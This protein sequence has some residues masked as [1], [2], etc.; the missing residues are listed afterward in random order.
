MGER[1]NVKASRRP[2]TPTERDLLRYMLDQH[3]TYRSMAARFGV[4]T[5]TIKRILMREGIAEFEGAKYAVAPSKS[6]QIWERP[7]INCRSTKPRPKWQY[8]CDPCK[9]G[10]LSGIPQSILEMDE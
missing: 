4:C 9:S 5:D 8:V 3:Y 6:E 2:L 10:A 1:H 7:C